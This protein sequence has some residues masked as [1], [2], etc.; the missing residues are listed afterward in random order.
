MILLRKLEELSF[1]EI[2]QRM[3]RNPDACRM[4]LARAMATL[5]MRL[6]DER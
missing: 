5:T 3:G 6:E 1:A 2:G 4:L